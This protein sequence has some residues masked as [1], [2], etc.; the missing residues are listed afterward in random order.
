MQPLFSL[1]DHRKHNVWM[2]YSLS[3][4]TALPKSTRNCNKNATL[5]R[6]PRIGL[7][8]D[9]LKFLKTAEPMPTTVMGPV[10]FTAYD[11]G[12]DIIPVYCSILAAVIVGLVIYVTVKC[13]NTCKQK[14]QLAKARAGELDGGGEGE[15][16]HS[17]SGVF[18][19]THSLYEPQLSKVVHADPALYSKLPPQKREEIE[20]LL[21]GPGA[22][23]AD[24]RN[25]AH[26]LGYDEERVATFGR[27]ED[28]AHTLLSDWSMR[29]DANLDVLCKALGRMDRNDIIE[30]L[31][32]EP[33]VTSVV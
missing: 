14:Q 23:R 32:S 26:L 21:D 20:Q 7:V 25:L 27:G 5:L 4:T 30:R 19:D 22:N 16:L 6:K 2:H 10:N 8:K 15:K 18:V 33:A 24:W 9:D 3:M 31:K 1:M 12:R 29:A 28:P 11:T 13:W 17:D